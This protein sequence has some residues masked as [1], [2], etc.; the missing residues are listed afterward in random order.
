VSALEEGVR[1]TSRWRLN[2]YAQTL[3]AADRAIATQRAY[4]SDAELFVVWAEERGVLSPTRVTKKDLRDYLVFMTN[5]GDARTSII[6]RRASL[7]GY[8]GWLVE[9]GDLESSPADRLLA[10]RPDRKLPKIVVR[11][12]LDALLD[13]DWGEDE[14]ATLDRAVCEVLYGAGLRVSE[15][16]GLD[17]VSVDFHQGLL[18]V[19]GKGR[20]ERVV[21]LHKK[22]MDAVHL[23]IE[24]ARDEVMRAH[25]PKEALFFNRRA[26]RL[27][28]RD[29]RRILD[30]RIELGHVNPH[31]LRHTYA[32]HLVEGGADL[33]IVQELLGHES[34]TTTQ[35]YTHVS[36]ARLQNIHRTTHPRG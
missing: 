21:P 11:E 28:P 24:D 4:T 30:R 34:L 13:D 32:T 15:L 17:L 16:C 12:Q 1:A 7:R 6:R 25:S 29:V 23:W 10:P 33:R 35:I 9:R 8:F 3:R 5:R 26:R 31:A 2:D 22:G 19:L 36:K 14:W 20:K 27:G 18:R